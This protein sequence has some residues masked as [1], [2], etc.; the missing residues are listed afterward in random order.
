MRS[1]TVARPPERTFGLCAA[2][3]LVVE[4]VVELAVELLEAEKFANVP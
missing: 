4:L 2:F 3:L 1:A